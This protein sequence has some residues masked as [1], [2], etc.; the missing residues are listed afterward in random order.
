MVIDLSYKDGTDGLFGRVVK[1]EI[2]DGILIFDDE[3]NDTRIIP[4]I[5]NVKRITISKH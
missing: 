4:L 2:V 3:Y 5:D 1:Y